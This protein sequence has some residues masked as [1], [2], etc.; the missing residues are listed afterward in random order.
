LLNVFA[1]G[2]LVL[3][4]VRLIVYDNFRTDTIFFNARFATYVV[5]I[6]VLAV[7]VWF[8]EQRKDETGKNAV[9][10]ASVALNVLALLALSHE[11]YD[12][13]N[14]QM[15]A[16]TRGSN[17]GPVYYNEYRAL[18]RAR[19]FTFSALWMVYGAILMAIG[20]WRR[21]AF[22][23]WQ[24]LVLIAVTIIKVFVYDVSELD[25]AY[26]ILSFIVLGVILLAISFVYQRDWLHLSKK[27][28]ETTPS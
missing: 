6:A 22:I 7:V 15:Y 11:V 26:R 3:G 10:F 1:I 2:A 9:V 14:R 23:R 20:F 27:R 19:D 25:R 24:A 8:G 18:T 28:Q 16:G 13:F 5:A 12:Y 21:S 4:V 17:Y